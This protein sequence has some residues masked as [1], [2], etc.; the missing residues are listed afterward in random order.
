ML[1]IRFTIIDSSCDRVK[2]ADVV[3]RRRE[4]AVDLWFTCQE[5]LYVVPLVFAMDMT[6][7][8]RDFPC[9]KPYAGQAFCPANPFRVLSAE[10]YRGNLTDLHSCV[11][12]RCFFPEVG[13]SDPV[14]TCD[15]V[16]WCRYCTLCLMLTSIAATCNRLGE[17]MIRAGEKC[18]QTPMYQRRWRLPA[19]RTQKY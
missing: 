5:S 10:G 16:A 17:R 4:T 1:T 12:R 18:F 2:A 9:L 13:V 6:P 14:C 8:L 11:C 3:C 7:F 19:T 15:R